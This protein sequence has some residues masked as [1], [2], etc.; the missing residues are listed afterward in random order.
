MSHA[1][2]RLIAPHLVGDGGG[3]RDVVRAVGALLGHSGDLTTLRSYMHLHDWLAGIYVSRPLAQRGLPASL[4][5]PLLGMQVAAVRRA[6]LRAAT[7]AP[8]NTDQV[9]RRGRPAGG[10]LET[11]TIILSR[12]IAA[13]PLPASPRKPASRAAVPAIE[14]PPTWQ[15]MVA[16]LSARTADEARIAAGQR[17]FATPLG[18]R[19]LRHLERLR[20]TTTRGR[21]GVALVRLREAPRANGA[22]RWLSDTE[23]D[24][25]ARLFC[26][27]LSLPTPR[28]NAL[29][30]AFATH[31]DRPRGVMRVDVADLQVTVDALRAAGCAA[32]E[33]T[34]TTGPKA[35]AIK[36]GSEGRTDRGFLWA[37]MFATA[38]DAAAPTAS[39]GIS[40]PPPA[41]GQH[42]SEFCPN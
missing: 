6:N 4:V 30:R 2:R 5:A 13:P 21:A 15:S 31:Y 9:R 28:R 20:A 29:C 39:F 19:T 24:R 7:P 22:M 8:A 26:G 17:D 36:V 38:V 42:T 35:A 25:L 10:S 41:E 27:V 33:V 16:L 32:G 23:S 3:S 18:Q 40:S 34:W 14:T 37:M 1:R 11:G 12:L